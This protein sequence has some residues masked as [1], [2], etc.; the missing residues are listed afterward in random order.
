MRFI[1]SALMTLLLLVGCTV[2]R[3]SAIFPPEADL[4]TQPPL[5]QND[6]GADHRILIANGLSENMTSVERADGVWNVTADAMETGQSPNFM[7]VHDGICYLVNSLSNS[8]Q[9]INPES[10]ETIREISTGAGTNPMV[11]DFVDEKTVMV[12]CYLSNEVLMIDIGED[13]PS[14]ERILKRIAMPDGDELPHD[15]GKTSYARP[16]GLAVVG[17]RC[18]VACANLSMVHVAGGP[19]VLVEIDTS[20]GEITDRIELAGRDTISV[21]HS[22]RFPERLIILSA[23][24]YEPGTGFAGDGMVESIDISS[25]E[26]FQAIEVDGAPF[27]GVVGPDDVLFLENGKAAEVV[28][29]DLREGTQLDG[30]ALPTYGESLSYASAIVALPGL[31]AVTNFN[32]DRMYLLNPEN[33]NMLAELATGDGPDAIAVVY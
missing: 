20:S 10:L 26:I 11:M 21:L 4:Q 5:S 2:G 24:S 8:I 30:W 7:T 32:A 25:G 6:D 1:L 17:D 18:Y 27:G 33:G 3:G 9:I 13:T 14:D 15:T 16:G 12:S 29:V 19:G 23:G 31:V 22:E 28:R